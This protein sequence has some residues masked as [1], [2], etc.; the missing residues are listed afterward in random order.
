MANP[1]QPG[2]T[3]QT[4]PDNDHYHYDNH[5]Q[6][7]IMIII[8][9]I[10]IFFLITVIV[11]LM[12]FNTWYVRHLLSPL[13]FLTRTAQRPSLP[14]PVA[15]HRNDDLWCTKTSALLYAMSVYLSDEN[16][17]FWGVIR[18]IGGRGSPGTLNALYVWLL[19]LFVS[20]VTCVH[21]MNCLNCIDHVVLVAIWSD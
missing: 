19:H 2:G 13:L 5:P 14:L 17:D 10:V 21:C 7:L 12:I 16:A 9:V 15:C 4:L 6:F 18:V 11:I 1:L 20:C 3:P 8:N